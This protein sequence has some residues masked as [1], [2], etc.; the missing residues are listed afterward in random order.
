ML[1]GTSVVVEQTFAIKYMGCFFVLGKLLVGK[2]V[3]VPLN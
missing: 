3:T 2:H 1:I